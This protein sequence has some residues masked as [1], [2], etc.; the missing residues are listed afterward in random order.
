MILVCRD[1]DQ[2]AVRSKALFCSRLTADFVAANIVEAMDV[3]L[4]R[5]LC[6]VVVAASATSR[7]I[8]Q[9]SPSGCV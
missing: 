4:L 6:V 3:R 1:Y 9:R 7:S 8:F 5:L 2:V